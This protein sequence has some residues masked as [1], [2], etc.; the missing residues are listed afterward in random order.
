MPHRADAVRFVRNRIDRDDAMAQRSEAMR[1]P[2]APGAE[3]DDG[4][5]LK[6]GRHDVAEQMMECLLTNAPVARV[7]IAWRNRRESA[8]I[9]RRRWTTA[10]TLADQAVLLR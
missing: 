8:V 10:L 2:R 5:R 1:K 7:R 6:A 3:I 9:R 4:A